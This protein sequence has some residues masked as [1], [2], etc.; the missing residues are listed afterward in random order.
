MIL[1]LLLSLLLFT[2]LY[3]QI[4]KDLKNWDIKIIIKNNKNFE[5]LIL[6]FFKLFI[7]NNIYFCAYYITN[8]WFIR[9]FWHFKNV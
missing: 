6:F 2:L 4:K 5:L 8:K 7:Q 1:T 9:T 3:K